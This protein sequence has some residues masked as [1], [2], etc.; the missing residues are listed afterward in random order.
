M[1]PTEGIDNVQDKG[2]ESAE[3]LTDLTQAAKL[4]FPAGGPVSKD[5]NPSRGD[6]E[7]AKDKIQK[8]YLRRTPS[9]GSTPTASAPSPAASMLC[10]PTQRNPSPRAAMWQVLEL[11]RRAGRRR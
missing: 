4:L 2:D 11:G 5:Q 7:S 1:L 10:R 6:R 8:P 9:S 3:C